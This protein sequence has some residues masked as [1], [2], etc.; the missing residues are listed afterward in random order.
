MS[1]KVCVD[2][3]S[4]TLRGDGS[5]VQRLPP[6]YSSASLARLAVICTC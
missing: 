3:E 4:G 5:E 6:F 2:P 1:H